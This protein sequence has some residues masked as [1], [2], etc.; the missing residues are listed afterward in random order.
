[1]RRPDL[2]EER[3]RPKPIVRLRGRH[4]VTRN[5]PGAGFKAATHRA[6][7]LGATGVLRSIRMRTGGGLAVRGHQRRNSRKR[8]HGTLQ[9][10]DKHHDG[11]EEL[12][13]HVKKLNWT[14]ASR[15]TIGRNLRFAP[16][17]GAPRAEFLFQSS[18]RPCRLSKSR[19]R[20]GG[21]VLE[22]RELSSLI[23]APVQGSKY[24]FAHLGTPTPRM[25]VFFTM[26]LGRR[27]SPV[28]TMA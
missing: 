25:S 6:L 13:I 9:S 26:R 2:R 23:L 28:P 15:Q 16:P 10:D 12:A 21:S 18:T 17:N 11:G 20:G 24:R 27:R 14:K 8:D 5:S 1:M 7:T 3:R 22:D 4:D 19:A